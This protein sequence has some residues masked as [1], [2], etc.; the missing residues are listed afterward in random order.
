MTLKK[1][2][3]FL[4]LMILFSSIYLSSQQ[5]QPI[6]EIPDKDLDDSV[7]YSGYSTRFYKDIVGNTIQLILNSN[8]GRIVNL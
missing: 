5:L 7:V 8:N 2:L 6:L 4:F 3:Y 1:F